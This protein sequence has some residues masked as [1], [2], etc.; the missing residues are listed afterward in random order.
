VNRSICPQDYG[1][2]DIH[3]KMFEGITAKANQGNST[4]NA[5]KM[6]GLIYS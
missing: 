1:K 6:E 5:L 2:R 4:Y 3:L